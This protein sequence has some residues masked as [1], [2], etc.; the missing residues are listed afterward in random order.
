MKKS[1]WRKRVNRILMGTAVFLLLLA[2][3]GVV[4]QVMGTKADQ[5]TYAPPGQLV[6]VG[7]Y[8]MHITCMGEGSPTVVLDHAGGTNSAEWGLVQPIVAGQT[9]VCAYD[10][11]GFGWSDPAPTRR[12]AA[13]SAQELHTLLSSAGLEGPYVLVGHSYGANVARVFAADFPE[14]SAGLVLVDPGTVFGRPK[15]P[16][17]VDAAWR[18][19]DVGFMN[20]APWLARLGVIRLAGALGGLP[21]HDDLP[22]GAFDALQLTNQFFD[23]L[24]AES[25]GMA[26]TSV[27]V[28][29]AEDYLTDQPLVVL[30]AGEPVDDADREVWTAVNA[31]IAA[32][33]SLGSHQVIGHAGHMALTV[34]QPYAQVTANAI[35]EIVAVV[36]STAVASID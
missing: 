3:T 13:Q 4:Y 30:S 29:A 16:A 19:A 18:T 35:L 26:D 12:T 22:A 10:R 1:V 15:V 31:A 32:R 7:G 25:Q 20:I 8:Q 28:L 14:E 36:R 23:T 9:R 27:Q 17:D 24:K 21:G 11:A 33:S 5:R 2:S 6:D 34:E